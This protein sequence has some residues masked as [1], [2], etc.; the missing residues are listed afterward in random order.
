M[1]A[2]VI[3]LHLYNVIHN[4]RCKAIAQSAI[5]PRMQIGIEKRTKLGISDHKRKRVINSFE[6][7]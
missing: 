4:Y 3:Y 1:D 2:H 5:S 6:I 7:N